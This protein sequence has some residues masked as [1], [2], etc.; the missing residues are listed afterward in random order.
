MQHS[1]YR[2][3]NK[4]KNNTL[5]FILGTGTII[6][7]V[8]LWYQNSHYNDL[9][10]KAVDP[11][12]TKNQSLVV[13]KGENVNDVAHDLKTANLVVDEDALKRYLKENSLDRK[14]VAGRFLLNP[15]LTIPEIAEY[16]TD[17][18]KSQL[19]LTV[20][21][22]Y[23]TQDIDEKLAD[24]QVI[25]PGEFV[26]AVGEFKDYDKY[27]FLDAAKEQNLAHPL[28]GFL[29]PDTYYLD[30]Q[31]FS[32]ADLIQLMLNDFQKRLGGD[33][34]TVPPHGWHDTITM[35]SIVEKEVKTE[36]DIPIVAGILWKRVDEGWFLG[37]DATLLYLKKDRSIDQN[38]LTEDSPYNTRI[39]KGLPPGP[40][41]NPGIKAIQATLHPE[42]SPYYFYL[43]KPGSGEVVYA[44]TN[45]EH[46]LN[47]ARYLY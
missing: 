45:D 46:N 31:N 16:L 24:L 18:K 2:R 34:N 10:A 39:N 26:K 22:G 47:K 1:T 4:R 21:E 6:V 5:W 42:E 12:D 29:F 37:A 7:L 35:A 40:I 25:Q 8:W 38:D 30:S 20:P 32:S 19:I 17:A 9:L 41:S 13:K 36:K 27:P 11:N 33:V 43:T 15:S 44:K 14:I 23:T 28:E 3:H